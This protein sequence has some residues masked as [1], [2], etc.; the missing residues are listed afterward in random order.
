MH[1]FGS[2]LHCSLDLPSTF[3]S[4]DSFSMLTNF[5]PNF[6]DLPISTFLFQYNFACGDEFVEGNLIFCGTG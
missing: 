1:T 3:A 5:C 4:T 6:S 2:C